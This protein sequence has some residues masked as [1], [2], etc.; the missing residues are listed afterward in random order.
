ME[1]VEFPLPLMACESE[2]INNFIEIGLYHK[3]VVDIEVQ[4]C[5]FN[6]DMIRYDMEF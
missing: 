3:E 2:L 1:N 6:T 5:V 4:A